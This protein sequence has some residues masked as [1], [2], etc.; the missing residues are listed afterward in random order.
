M[1]KEKKLP[2]LKRGKWRLVDCFI[3]N[4]RVSPFWTSMFIFTNVVW[5]AQ[6]YLKLFTT[7]SFVDT[8]LSVLRGDA[9][10]SAIILPLVSMFAVF[11]S[12]S[13]ID[14]LEQTVRNVLRTKIWTVTKEVFLK[15]QASLKYKYVEDSKTYDLIGRAC[16]EPGGRM[17][18]RG[19]RVIWIAWRVMFIVSLI[20]TEFAVFSIKDGKMTLLE[21]APEVTKEDIRANTEAEYEEAP[22]VRVMQ[23]VEEPVTEAK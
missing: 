1:K 19:T 7:A 3:F 23:G 2:E 14:T 5:N 8:A 15:K 20:V 21:V 22:E 13:L 9:A 16:N 18:D 11:F 12:T 10:E 17:Y 6:P 4:F